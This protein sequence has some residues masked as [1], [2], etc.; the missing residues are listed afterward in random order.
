MVF[1]QGT[2]FEMYT[3]TLSPTFM[4]MTFAQTAEYANQEIQ[5]WYFCLRI[6]FVKLK[7]LLIAIE[8]S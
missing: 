4:G 5:A 8:V 2:G 6:C 7:L 3:E 1:I